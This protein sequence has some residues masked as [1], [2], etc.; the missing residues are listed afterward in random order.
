MGKELAAATIST[1][2]FIADEYRAILLAQS[3]K[4]LGKGLVDHTDAAHSLDTFQNDGTDIALRQFGFPC[5]QIV[6]RQIGNMAIGID[7]GDNLG[8][9]GGFYG[10]TGAAMEGLFCRKHT[11]SAVGKRC[12]F[13]G[14]L[15]GFRT[16]VNEEKLVIIV[17]AKFSHAF[18]KLLLQGIDYRIAVKAQRI[19]LLRQHFDIMGMAVADADDSMSAIEVQIFLSLLIPHLASLSLD[20]VHIEEGIHIV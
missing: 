14:I 8:I 16:A 18:C 12:Q 7:G 3:R 11:G 4:S 5:R 13:Q 2:D 20:N 6:Q 15:V 9:V 17:S 19:E 1:L 10:Q